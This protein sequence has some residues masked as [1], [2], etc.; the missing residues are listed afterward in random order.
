MELFEVGRGRVRL[1]AA[2]FLTQGGQ[3]SIYVRGDRAY[4]VYHDPQQVIPAAKLQ[5]LAVLDHDALVRPEAAL[6]DRKNRP[7]GYAMRRV[8][9]AHV[10]CELFNRA[11]RDRLGISPDGVLALV[12]QLQAGVHHVHEHDVLIVDLNEM[13]F[14]LDSTL[15]RL[16]FIDVDSYQTRSFPATAIMDSVRD[17]H[18][19]RFSR[20]TD[21]FSFAVVAFQ[22]L[23]GIH[24]FK[25]KHPVLKD[26]D[27][28]M[29]ANVSVLNREVKVPPVC[30]PFSV[31]PPALLEW[32][33]IVFEEG[34]RGAPPEDLAAA[35]HVVFRPVLLSGSTALRVVERCRFPAPIILPL[36]AAGTSGAL[37]ADGL[38]VR[39]TRHPVPPDARVV[40]TPR[41]RQLVAAWTEAGALKL[42][43]VERQGRIPV[44]WQ[45]EGIMACAERLYVKQGA[46]LAM[47]ELL[48]LPGGIRAALR[49]VANVM[50]HATRLWDGVA[51]QDV[52]G[53]CWVT[54]CPQAGQAHSLRLPELDGA[55]VADAR[56]DGG[57]LM[58][59]AHR[60]GR[61]E[62]RVFRFGA[63]YA[64]Y[65][66]RVSDDVTP[67]GL[68]FV[69]LE[70]GVCVHLTET[71]DLEV[72]R[73]EK[74]APGM[75]LLQSP[76]LGGVRLFR[77]GTQVLGVRDTVVYELSLRTD[78]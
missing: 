43:D 61:Y 6:L 17:R 27:S 20:E 62:C 1:E 41:M 70:R 26:L 28:R 38:R 32:F 33:R 51:L 30:Q 55:R 24:P 75:K 5:E 14:L 9:A 22:M 3:A 16:H 15:Q 57:V 46:S 35:V 69:T 67:A 47:V 13:N 64:D 25:G 39:S 7:V 29:R 63:E 58:V 12:R 36:P 77:D 37:T 8:A 34:W 73:R 31:I 18:A 72:F 52:L 40:L 76:G 78:Q 42:Y 2:D 45:V 50:A 4:K 11:F 48:E 68:N 65:D 59:L 23:T 44:D 54:L 56:F 10:L 60:D 19:T 53:C 66:V 71:G 74:G 49:P 21:W